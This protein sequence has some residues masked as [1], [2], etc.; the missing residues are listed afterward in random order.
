MH[1]G[2][3]IECSCTIPTTSLVQYILEIQKDAEK[4]TRKLLECPLSLRLSHLLVCIRLSEE[5]ITLLAEQQPSEY[6]PSTSLLTIPTTL[7]TF[8][9][10]FISLSLFRLFL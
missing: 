9:I 8:P 1:F 6:V 5:N 10:M 2:A 3:L 7:V 4:S